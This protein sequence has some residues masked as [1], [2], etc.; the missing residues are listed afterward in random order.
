MKIPRS[1]ASFGVVIAVVVALSAC[2]TS[3]DENFT[4]D[5]AAHQRTTEL[6]SR[7]LALMANSEEAYSRHSGDA[8]ALNADMENAYQL[9]AAAP[10]NDLVTAE[11][12]AMKDPTRDLYGGFARRWQ[13]SGVVDAATRGLW[14]DKVTTRFNYILCLEAAKKTRA[15]R[16]T[17]PEVEAAASP[18]A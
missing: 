16:C 8:E 18:P 9:A 5:A 1:V 7:A 10:N 4:F 12:V 6:K 3:D 2:R 11:W 17:P 15:G 13:A 14:M